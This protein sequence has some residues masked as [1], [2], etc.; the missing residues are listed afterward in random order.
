MCVPT[1]TLNFQIDPT[2]RIV[3]D[4][5]AYA[6]MTGQTCTRMKQLTGPYLSRTEYVHLGYVPLF[7]KIF[8]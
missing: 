1:S 4:F 6:Q 5:V 7:Q 3:V 2:D 8:L